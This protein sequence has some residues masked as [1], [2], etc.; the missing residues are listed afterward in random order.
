MRSDPHGPI[1]GLLFLLQKKMANHIYSN[2]FIFFRQP[3][4]PNLL[5]LQ[6]KRIQ[7][8]FYVVIPPQFGYDPKKDHVCIEFGT[9]S[10]GGWNS[11]KWEMSIER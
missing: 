4:D 10:L 3:N 2:N 11:N 7:M 8:E 1:F 5:Y 6:Q 9:N